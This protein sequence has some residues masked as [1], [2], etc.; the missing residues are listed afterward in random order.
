MECNHSTDATYSSKQLGK[1]ELVNGDSIKPKAH[2]KDVKSWL[3]SV[4]A[5]HGYK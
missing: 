4:D 2:E 3:L 5:V 1:N